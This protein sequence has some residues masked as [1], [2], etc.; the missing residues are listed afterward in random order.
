MQKKFTSGSMPQLILLV[1]LAE[2]RTNWKELSR[3]SLGEIFFISLT[4]VVI[5]ILKMD[6]T[7]Q[8]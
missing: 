1:T 8:W 7:F 2:S 4:K 6:R 5:P 3:A